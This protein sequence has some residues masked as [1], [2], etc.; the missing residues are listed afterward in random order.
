MA[1]ATSWEKIFGN[2]LSL[3]GLVY[4][5]YMKEH[6]KLNSKKTIFKWAI[7]V[8]PSEEDIEWQKKT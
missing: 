3:R 2:H 6:S 4:R 7:D 1:V 5:R 8:H